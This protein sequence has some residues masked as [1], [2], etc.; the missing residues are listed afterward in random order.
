M[1]R[2][3]AMIRYYPI[4]FLTLAAILSLWA[5]VNSVLV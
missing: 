2:R 4:V 5:V 3:P 1:Y